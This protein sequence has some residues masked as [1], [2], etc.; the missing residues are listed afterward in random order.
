MTLGIREY[1]RHRKA[2]GLAGGTHKA[3]QAAIE[4][5]RL[6]KSLTPDRKRIRAAELADREWAATTHVDRVPLTGPTAAG[7]MPPELEE[8]RARREAAE[9]GL[10]ELELAEKRRALVPRNV[11]EMAV[12]EAFRRCRARIERVAQDL[13]RQAPDISPRQLGLLQELLLEATEGI[14]DASVR[15]HFQS[16]LS[17]QNP[18]TETTT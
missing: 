13:A 6:S 8:S 11:V 12:A 16:L 1:A 9:A 14:N 18:S 10:S 2:Q 7:A 3:V 17:D 4:S 5:G 15:E